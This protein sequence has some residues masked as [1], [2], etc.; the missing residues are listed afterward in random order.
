MREGERG[1][2]LVLAMIFVIISTGIVLTGA[3]IERG[4]AEKTNTEFRV[5]AQAVQFAR[6]GLTEAISWFRRQNTQPVLAFE[7][8]VDMEASPPV[9]DTQETEVGIVREFRVRGRTWGRYEV[10]K[11]WDADPI[12]ERRDWREQMRAHD[13]SMERRA[14]NAGTSW[15]IRSIGYVFEREDESLPFDQAPNSVIAMEVVEAEILRRKLAPPGNAAVAANRGDWITMTTNGRIEGTTRGVG[16]Y[17]PRNTGSIRNTG[18]NISG[19]PATSTSTT[20]LDLTPENI[21]GATFIDL[22]A[23]A[24]LVVTDIADFPRTLAENAT[25][26][27]D[28]GGAVTFDRDHPLRGRGL[29]YVRGDCTIL[30]GSNSVFNGLLYVAGNFTMNAPAEIEG[31]VISTGRVTVNGSGDRSTIRYGDAVLNALRQDVGQYRY[32]GA[33][34]RMHARN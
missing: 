10:W 20:A 28:T 23:S 25:I 6:A 34:R 15:R 2:A 4:N 17:Y 11:R 31:C 18:G 16:A 27:V 13:V 26:I 12:E 14:G 19:N 5:G 29:V 3:M 9:I 22:R 1:A 32:L 8:I 24:D 21:F 30:A 33:F 7:P